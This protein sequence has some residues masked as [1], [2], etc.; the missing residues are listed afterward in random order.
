MDV[1]KRSGTL[2]DSRVQVEQQRQNQ[3]KKCGDEYSNERCKMLHAGAK[4]QDEEA[5]SLEHDVNSRS[6]GQKERVDV[7]KVERKERCGQRTTINGDS[8]EAA[9]HYPRCLPASGW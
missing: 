8:S 4:R 7:V 3:T 1:W 6:R 5:E 2:F 9:I